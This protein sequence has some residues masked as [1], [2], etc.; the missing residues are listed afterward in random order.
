MKSQSKMRK[1]LVEFVIL[2]FLFVW[3]DVTKV[4]S[5]RFQGTKYTGKFC[6]E[7]ITSGRTCEPNPCLNDGQCKTFTANSTFEKCVCKNGEFEIFSVYS[8]NIVVSS[9]R[10]LPLSVFKRRII[11][12]GLIRLNDKNTI[13]VVLVFRNSRYYFKQVFSWCWP[14]TRG[15]RSVG[16]RIVSTIDRILFLLVRYGRSNK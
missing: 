9:P 13:G 6:N 1:R 3:V 11:Q 8:F 15:P 10:F 2:V 5:T 4:Q 7:T 14:G 12:T 16:S